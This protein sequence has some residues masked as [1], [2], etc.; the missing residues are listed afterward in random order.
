M[1]FKIYEFKNQTNTKST[2]YV[3]EKDESNE[4]ILETVKKKENFNEWF[5]ELFEKNSIK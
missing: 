4:I 2:E 5:N 1:L 3:V